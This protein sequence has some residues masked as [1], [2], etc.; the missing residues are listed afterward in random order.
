MWNHFISNISAPSEKKQQQQ[1]P[2]FW[3]FK[4]CVKHGV[5]V[6]ALKSEIFVFSMKIHAEHRNEIPIQLIDH[7]SVF[8]ALGNFDISYVSLNLDCQNAYQLY[9]KLFW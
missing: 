3:A 9:F 2:G 1:I 7:I 5:Y 4:I 6:N 8:L